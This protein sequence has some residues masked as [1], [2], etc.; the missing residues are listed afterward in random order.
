MKNSTK[1]RIGASALLISLVSVL[2]AGAVQAHEGEL[3]VP[4]TTTSEPTTIDP[5][6][7]D[8]NTAEGME[9]FGEGEID[10]R[11]SQNGVPLTTDGGGTLEDVVTIDGAT[12]TVD[13]NSG[14]STPIVGIAIGATLIAAIGGGF[15]WKRSR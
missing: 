13:P 1:A 5:G 15:L 6:T 8:P 9:T 10:P 12:A 14:S 7:I 11:T 2:G 4:T 3:P